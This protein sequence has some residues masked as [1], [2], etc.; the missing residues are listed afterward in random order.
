MATAGRV[1]RARLTRRL[2]AATAA[3]ALAVAVSCS[4]DDAAG[5]RQAS[6]ASQTATTVGAAAC[7][8]PS[9]WNVSDSAIGPIRI[10]APADSVLHVCPG[11]RDSTVDYRNMETADTARMLFVPVG[12]RDTV[13]VTIEP[14]EQRVGAIAVRSG[15]FRTADSLGIGTPITRWRGI[16]GVR[17]L[18]GDHS[19]DG[20]MVVPHHCGLIFAISGGDVPPADRTAD[21]KTLVGWPDTV[22]ITEIIVGPCSRE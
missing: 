19:D 6:G 1:D 22:R 10:G 20:A 8:D 12:A 11:T 15:P 18:Y 13:R 5:D 9:L 16:A 7:G 4:R 17:V 3:I 14:Y 2:H 21:A